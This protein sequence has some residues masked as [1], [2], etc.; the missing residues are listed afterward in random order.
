MKR[1]ILAILLTFAV[2]V[3]AIADDGIRRLLKRADQNESLLNPTRFGQ[4]GK[5]FEKSSDGIFVCDNGSAARQQRGVSQQVEL[6]QKVAAPVFASAWSRSENVGGSPDGDYSVYLDLTYVD[7]SHLWGQAAAFPVGTN[8]WTRREV[9]VFPDKPIKSL[10]FYTLFRHHSGKASFRDLELRTITV[11]DGACLF[12]G[13]PI[14][15]KK[16]EERKRKLFLRDVAANGDFLDAEKGALGLD[17]KR[18]ASP[19]V[20]EYQLR[21]RDD[22]DHVLTAVYTVP[23]AKKDL[24][25]CEHPRKTVPISGQG[26]FSFTTGCAAGNSR[27]SRYPFAAVAGTEKGIGVGIDM[28]H[29]TVF[30]VAYNADTE[31]LFV[32]CDIALTP[33]KPTA[34]LRFC[35]FEFDPKLEF[36]GALAAFYQLF[37]EQ[38]RCR[39]PK[40]G[41]WMPFAKISKIDRWEDFGFMFKEGNDET[42]WDDEQGILTFRYTEPTTWWMS[43]PKELPRTME[44]ALAQAEKHAAQGNPAAKVLFSCGMKDRDGNI[45]GKFLDTP[46]TNG[47]VWSMNEQPGLPEPNA[48]ATKWNPEIFA[49]LYGPHKK[50]DLDGE[51]VDSA[52][53]YVTAQLDF[54]REHFAAC[55]RPLAFDRETKRPAIYRGLVLQEYAEKIAADMHGIGKLTMANSTP[56]SLCWLV[57]HFDVLGTETNWN[58]DGKWSPMSDAE[59]LYRRALC[60]TKPYCFLMNTKFDDFPYELTQRFMKRCLAYGMFPGFFSA[61]ASTGHYFSRPELYDRDRPLFKKYVPLCKM[62]AEAGWNPVTSATSSE[63]SVYVERF[64]KYLTVFNNSKEQK[65]TTITLERSVDSLK[66]HVRG[67]LIQ[68]SNGCFEVVLAPE[69]VLVVEEPQ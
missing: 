33:E 21:S 49:R 26:E 30:R 51:Y 18:D 20:V 28:L 45:A 65:T 29:P 40:Q 4:Y 1:F 44:V 39:T 14:V 63:Y 59:L 38:F 16:R 2:F 41:I 37:P 60:G 32:A 36:R 9:V 47:I 17:V 7:G 23:V 24:R 50:A 68:P 27:I 6:N 12:D 8:D 52:E 11:S 42:A 13:V 55:K 22:A 34:T 66:E 19:I 46:W 5:G 53:G 31:E 54:A 15:T 35:C 67:G 56:S 3:S 10:M 57:P 25:W 43:I 61:D 64:G 48:F 62:V 69:D 58:H